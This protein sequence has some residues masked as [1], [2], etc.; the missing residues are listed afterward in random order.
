[1]AGLTFGDE[2]TA[3]NAQVQALQAKGVHAFVVVLHAGGTGQAKYAGPTNPAATGLSADITSLVG[4]LDADVDVVLTAHSHSFA[5]QLVKNAG[6]KDVLVT[7]AYS[8]GTAYADVD[9]TVDGPTQE[10]TAKTAQIVDTFADVGPGLTPDAGVAA[11]VAAAEAK[12]APLVSAQV[13]TTTAVLAKA[14]PASGESVLGDLVA[15]A[16]RATMAADFGITN[17]GGLRADLPV[18]CS[19]PGACVV[20]WNDCFT[21]QPFFNVVM[22]VTI[23]GQQLLDV[24]EQQWTVAGAPKFLQVSGFTYQWSASAAVG[25]KVVAGSLRKSDGTAID[26]ATSYT[27]ALNNFLQ[28]GG[29]GFSVFT[30]TTGAV[31]GPTDIDALVA[32]LKLQPVP[33]GPPASGRITS[34]P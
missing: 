6:G 33:V 12:V 16:H 23:T 10:I 34:V 17:P 22:K 7:Q 19:T 20:T 13:T 32:Y 2:A 24:L 3:I 15:D 4:R 25:A 8:S 26:A 27:L 29:D 18:T 14:V 28:G 1:M 9:L 11:L 30:A 21:A 31:A 5:N